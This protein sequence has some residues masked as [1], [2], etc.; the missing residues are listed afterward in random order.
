MGRNDREQAAKGSVIRDLEDL[1][2]SPGF[3]VDL[4]GICWKVLSREWLDLIYTLW[5]ARGIQPEWPV[6]GCVTLRQRW[7]SWTW[8]ALREGA[9]GYAVKVMG[10][11]TWIPCGSVGK[12][13]REW[14]ATTL[15][16]ECHRLKWR[17]LGEAGGGVLP[18]G[19]RSGCTA[20][21]MFQVEI[22]SRQLDA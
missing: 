17:A 6:R 3:I 18:S 14:P 9:L 4:T 22:P 15:G 11:I 2:K 19:I 12:S 16:V 13:R 8:G 7:L 5:K 10:T 20:S 21:E 1:T